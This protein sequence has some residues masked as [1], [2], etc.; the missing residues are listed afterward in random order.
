MSK[1]TNAFAPLDHMPFNWFQWRSMITTGMG[2]FTDGYDLS[3]VGIVLTLVL[4]SFGVHSLTGL[5]SSLLAGSALI[6][7]A[8]G[9]VL[10]GFLGNRGRKAFYGWDVTIMA[11]GA[12]LQAIVPNV[13]A[14]IA[15][16]FIMGIGIGAD[17]VLS[18]V[19]M[20]EHANA[21]DRGKT[22]AA[23]FGLTWGLGATTAA[24]L[25]LA[26]VAAHVPPGLIW[27]IVLG[28]GAVPALSV[29]ALR[30]KMPETAR[31]LGRIKGQ[32]DEARAVITQATQVTPPADWAVSADRRSF[33]EFWTTHGSR[34]IV[35]SVLWFL[36]DMVA[37]SGILFG[38]SLIAKGLGLSPGTFQLLME[39]AFVVPGALIA[40]LLID[41]WGRK[42]LQVLGFVGIAATLAAF[43][44]YQQSSHAVPLFSLLLYGGYNLV[45]QAGPGSVS[46]AGMLGVE[47][48][49]TKIRSV[50]QGVTVAS[51]RVGASLSA[52]VFPALFHH[53]G[54]SGAVGFLAS[55]GLL[56]AGITLIGVPETRQRSLEDT[57]RDADE[58]ARHLSEAWAPDI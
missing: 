1:S 12:I 3:S 42:P 14:L 23:G 38:P 24:A 2:V 51:G 27:R 11:V 10:F 28:F 39:F 5:Q 44:V 13:D 47:L 52:F 50:V 48:A 22:I 9:A 54:E 34:I 16:R 4:A 7:A 43:G 20:A 49:P 41:R 46:A 32:A 45:S 56:A 18:P 8:V 29:I 33:H 55:I 19:I 6:G 17:Y 30:R 25:Y 31:F 15:V 35:A 58:P 36:F 21:R 53:W 40:L 37:Y 26:L 57:A